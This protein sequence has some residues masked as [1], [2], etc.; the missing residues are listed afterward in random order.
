[1]GHQ[2][3][4]IRSPGKIFMNEMVELWSENKSLLFQGP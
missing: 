1:M 4:H 2:C 3:A